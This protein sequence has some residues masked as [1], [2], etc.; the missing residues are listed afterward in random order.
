MRTVLFWTVLCCT[1]IL[2]GQS[3]SI[4]S[5]NVLEKGVLRPI[6]NASIAINGFS[7]VHLTN[8]EGE[9]HIETDQRGE[10]VLE[11]SSLGFNP[12][13]F[14]IFLEGNPID[15]GQIY[16]EK[17]LAQ[18]KT[19]NLITLTEGD[20]L[21]D[22]EA[23]SGA[24]GLLQ[25]TRDI[26]LNRAAFDFGQAF[27]KVRGFD[28]RN[29]T[30]LLNGIPMN[31]FF[32]GRPQ[33][34][35]WGGLNDV[36]RNQEFTQGLSLNPYTFGGILG[37]TNMDMRPSG[38]RPGVRLSSSTSNRTYRGR[39]MATYSSG[40]RAN[41]LAY[42]FSASRRWA[43][44]GY[45]EGTLYDAYSFF[46]SLEYSLNTENGLMLTAVFARNR[47][48]RSAAITEEVFDLMGNRYNPYWGEQEGKVRNSREREI[49]EPIF[50]LNH[51]LRSKKFNWTTGI[52]YQFGNNAR[53]RVGYFNTPNPD[54][55]YYRYL[56]SYHI[57]GSIG[58]DFVNANLAREGF[59]NNPQIQWQEIYSANTANNGPAGYLLYDDVAQDNQITGSS[60]L[61]FKPNEKMNFGAGVNF[62]TTTSENF[63]RINDLL[64]ADFHQDMDA[65]SGTFNDINGNLEKTAGEKFSYHYL[66][67]ASQLEAFGQ[68]EFKSRK[69]SGFTS[70]SFSNFGVQ[71]EGLFANERFLENSFGTSEK[72]SFSSLGLKGGFTY[73]LSGRHWFTVNG[74]KLE[75]P[76]T[77]QNVFIN[78][79][80]NNEIVSDIQKETIT[81][82]DLNYFVRLPDI[83]GRI[84]AFYTRFQNTTDI[85]FFFVD[86]GLGSDFVQEVITG[87][88]K[89]HK[90][91]EFGLE[92]QPSSSVKLSA[93]GN[94]GQYVYASDPSVQINFDTAGAE[95]DLIDPQGN[96]DL[97]IAQL[98]DLK[99]AQGPQ[100]ALSIGVEYRSPKYWWVG[101]TTNYLADNQ[102]NLATITR[103]RSFLLDPETGKHFPDATEE[104][105]TKL[106]KQQPLED[107]YLLNLIGGKSWLV[108]KKYISAFLSVNNLFNTVFKSGGYEQSRNGN[109]GQLQQ[110]NLSGSPLFGPKYWYS[111]G[112]TYFLNL[113]ISF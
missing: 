75:R 112:R 50:M 17:D 23:V 46:G 12:K 97:G 34:N 86:S 18:E 36:V 108:Q 44:E 53:S 101:A 6:K 98:K 41:G 39:L 82:L 64:G 62:R 40:L 78:P 31:K 38:L 35:N 73:F 71:R 55:T 19:D 5:G 13:R 85:N 61:V 102:I 105:V 59:I 14:A 84:S 43:Q 30:V 77:L 58:A 95:E 60:T 4:I 70:A 81:T 96:I 66:L 28:S 56:P 2:Y 15:L 20:F 89:L 27:F 103:T 8:E 11:I 109:F 52:A 9:F 21:D 26:F 49:F 33:W 94:F 107:I 57:N 48:G 91:I 10:Q 42:T 100:T 87:L 93:A 68:V 45:V 76:P 7:E 25:S 65:F 90:G 92:Y 67:D 24:L 51:F 88:D 16:L 72:V 99:L 37:N 22:G 54:P 63:A 104:A 110:D 83:T 47:R 79:R 29:G 69:W 1:T 106:L 74:A 3:T 113:A 32:D 80:E 111:Y